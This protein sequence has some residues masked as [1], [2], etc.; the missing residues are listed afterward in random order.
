MKQS[1][2]HFTSFNGDDC[3]FKFNGASSLWAAIGNGDSALRYLNRS[4]IILN[5]RT[6]PTVTPNTL[7]SENGWPTFESPIASSRSELDMLLQSWG[8]KIRVFPA[9]PSEWKDA[10][11][12]NLRAEGGFVMS[13]LKKD[14]ITQFIS[15][16]SLA[17]EP[18]IIK[19]DMKGTVKLVASKKVKMIQQGGLITLTLP[20]GEEAIIYSGTKPTSFEVEPLQL[21]AEEYNSWGVK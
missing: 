8:G 15:I 13:A 3:M 11:F 14:G 9:F 6:G 4:L 1:I 18:C 17:G 5:P 16:K 12:Y 19:T 2:E 20:K 21:K 7:Y 10:S